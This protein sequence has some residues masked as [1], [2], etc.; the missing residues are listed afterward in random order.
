MI[1]WAEFNGK[2]KHMKGEKRQWLVSRERPIIN[3]HTLAW[4]VKI[5]KRHTH[6]Q[7]HTNYYALSLFRTLTVLAY[8]LN[9]TESR[10]QCYCPQESRN[11]FSFSLSKRQ[12]KNGHIFFL[13][14]IAFQLIFITWSQQYFLLGL[15]PSK[16]L[17]FLKRKKN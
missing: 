13:S 8:E 4:I 11:R 2:F 10:S 5:W 14:C 17:Q 15:L 9:K 12:K 16:G 3:R 7:R 1:W 6:I